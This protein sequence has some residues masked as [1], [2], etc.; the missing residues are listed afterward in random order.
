MKLDVA[1]SISTWVDAA[2]GS[3]YGEG[4]YRPGVQ[5]RLC[6]T[7]SFTSRNVIDMELNRT[8]HAVLWIGGLLALSSWVCA[9]IHNLFC[10][11]K[12]LA[13]IL[14]WFGRPQE[15]LRLRIKDALPFGDTSS[16][17]EVGI[18]PRPILC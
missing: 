10:E 15:S 14:G 12:S 13:R 18:Q 8:I 9:S 16:V 5:C 17:C 3:V 1:D 11:H 7:C 2:S 4:V 6:T